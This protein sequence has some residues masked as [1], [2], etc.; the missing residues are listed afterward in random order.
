MEALL[1]ETKNE[2]NICSDASIDTL[3][4]ARSNF[5]VFFYKI[6]QH[7]VYRVHQEFK[8]G[9]H[10]EEWGYRFQKYDKT[11]TVSARY[12]SK[13]TTILG[14]LAWQMYRAKRP[15]TEW[16]FMGYTQ[17]LAAYH[18]KYLKRYI[19]ALPEYFKDWRSLTPAESILHYRNNFTEFFC[20]PE[21]IQSFKRGRHPHG[22]ICDD[23]LLDP[24]KKLDISQLLKISKIF[25][26]QIMNMPKEELHVV[27]TP[28]DEQ[29]L[30]SELEHLPD[31]D[32][33]RYP[34][35][36]NR[37]KKI[38]LWPEVW[39]W[40]RLKKKENEIRQRAYNKE[41][42]C[43]PV[44]SEEGYFTYEEVDGIIEARYKN[45][46]YRTKAKLNGYSY[47]GLDIGKKRH[48]SHLSVFTENR[49][50][51]L[52]QTASVWMDGWD[53]TNQLETCRQAIK[54]FNMQCLK[55]DDTR[56]EFEGFKERGDLPPEME[57]VTFTQKKK[58]EMAAMFEKGVKKKKVALL[59]DERQRR[60]ILNVD[61][62]L[63]SMETDEGHGDSFWSNALA[64]NAAQGSMANIRIL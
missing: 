37:A 29:D 4:T 7:G 54:N 17:D 43:H 8:G 59:S 44:R 33:R 3:E 15:Y 16:L 49:R 9:H 11:A 34:A 46:G 58:F 1:T 56:A 41:F 62:D 50:G 40:E 39:P 13:T 2:K 42:L 14:Y 26:E 27:G 51:R 21:G 55:Y 48:P 47:G 61:N 19:S 20:E 36:V 45:Y 63:K 52:I 18:L 57:G 31:W 6:F 35:E 10:L 12:H 23:I 22:I 53:Y 28:Q 30:F 32:C 25:R 5:L 38:A 64:I 24:E 60:Q